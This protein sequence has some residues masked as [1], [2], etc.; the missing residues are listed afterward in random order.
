[1]D[2]ILVHIAWKEPSISCP[3]SAYGTTLHDMKEWKQLGI[4]TNKLVVGL[5]WYGYMYDYVCPTLF[6]DN[7]CMH[8]RY[9]CTIEA[10]FRVGAPCS[11]AA[12]KQLTL[13]DVVENFLL[14]STSGRL[15]MT[16]SKLPYFN[17]TASGGTL[18]QFWYDNLQNLKAKYRFAAV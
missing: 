6:A 7:T 11:D 8:H 12:G 9:A 15:Y 10:I 18:R 14:I 17:Y 2:S 1:M 3:N 16:T 5:P 13:N 4:S